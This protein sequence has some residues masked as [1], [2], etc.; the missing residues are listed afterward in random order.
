M[1]VGYQAWKVYGIWIYPSAYLYFS[2]VLSETNPHAESTAFI[3]F[4]SIKKLRQDLLGTQ[5][6]RL[7]FPSVINWKSIE[8][9]ENG[10][11]TSVVAF[12]LCLLSG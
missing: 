12:I 7:V 3:K 4:A 9:K 8:S 11:H 1:Y 5:D 2:S 6:R 10:S